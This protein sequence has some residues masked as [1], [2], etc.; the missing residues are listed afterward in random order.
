MTE[1][2][3]YSEFRQFGTDWMWHFVKRIRLLIPSLASRQPRWIY[4]LRLVLVRTL[5]ATPLT[6]SLYADR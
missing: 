2:S 4:M 5:D 3:Y 1:F 6:T